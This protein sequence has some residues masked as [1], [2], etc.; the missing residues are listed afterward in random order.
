MGEPVSEKLV[1][2]VPERVRRARASCACVVRVPRVRASAAVPPSGLCA[3][4]L[5]P[6]RRRRRER[7][8]PLARR[9]PPRSPGVARPRRR[10]CAPGRRG[11]AVVCRL[12]FSVVS[13]VM[14]SFGIGVSVSSGLFACSVK[15]FPT[16]RNSCLRPRFPVRFQPAAAEPRGPCAHSRGGLFPDA[17]PSAEQ[18]GRQG[19]ELVDRTT[20]ASAGPGPGGGAHPCSVG[21]EVAG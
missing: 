16:D 15:S 12:G 8:R 9:G 3:L 10:L 5:R 18:A 7:R 14:S 13:A 2:D 21:A 17:Q 19:E 20:R 1:R 6:P 11:V 4:P